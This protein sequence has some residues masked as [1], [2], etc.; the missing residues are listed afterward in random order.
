MRSG[1][2]QG[3]LRRALAFNWINA[4]VAVPDSGSLDLTN[5]LVIDV[6]I[7]SEVGWMVATC[8]S[9]RTKGTAY[10]GQRTWDVNEALALSPKGTESK[11]RT[12]S[13]K[14]PRHSETSRNT[15]ATPFSTRH[16]TDAY[17]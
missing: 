1:S 6:F 2:P 16:R 9:T 10:L 15:F 12:R 11:T 7:R 5:A 13:R 17:P 4:L 8:E 14:Q 3:S